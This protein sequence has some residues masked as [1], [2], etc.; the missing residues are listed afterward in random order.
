MIPASK[1]QLGEIMAHNEFCRKL[2]KQYSYSRAT[3]ILLIIDPGGG[4]LPAQHQ[5]IIKIYTDT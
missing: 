5:V 4:L 2:T 3:K 1:L